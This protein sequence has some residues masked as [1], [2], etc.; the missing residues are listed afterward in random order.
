Q[1]RLAGADALGNRSPSP[2]A[3]ARDAELGAG[4]AGAWSRRSVAQW[5]FPDLPDDVAVREYG[6]ELSLY[7][8]LIDANGRVELTLIPP[9]PAARERHRAGVRRLLLKQLPQQADIVRRR[10]LGDRELVL[11]WHGIGAGEQLADDLL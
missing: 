10:V 8:A 7:P 9:G 4:H 1:Q 11:S 2:E 3:P 5:D 6:T